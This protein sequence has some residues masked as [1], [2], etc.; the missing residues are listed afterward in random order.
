M[1]TDSQGLRPGRDEVAA[2]P[3]AASGGGAQKQGYEDGRRSGEKS[4][5]AG[6]RCTQPSGR[7]RNG[8][9]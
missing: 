1:R 2:Q 6:L 3:S 7:N 4:A 5:R 8:F 9:R